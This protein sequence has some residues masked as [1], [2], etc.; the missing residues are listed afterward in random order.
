[1]LP[2]LRNGEEVEEQVWADVWSH[3]QESTVSDTDARY[4]SENKVG[5]SS[6]SPELEH[7]L[8]DWARTVYR[9]VLA[10]KVRR[11]NAIVGAYLLFGE[12]RLE[13]HA[14][15]YSKLDDIGVVLADI[16]LAPS[17]L[18]EEAMRR[19]SLRRLSW[20]MHQLNG[21]VGRAN[22]AL[23]DVQEFLGQY[24]QIGES[25]VPNE[26]KAK[27][28][29]AMPGGV[30]LDRQTL[31]N[32]LQDAMKAV[33]DVRKIAYQVR[34]L[35]RVQGA[36]PKGAF[37]LGHLLRSQCASCPERLPE[38]D[39]QT[40]GIDD[41]QVSANL[42]SI[43]EAIEEI[44]NNSFREL[45][46]RKVDS[47][48]IQVKWWA[49]HDEAWF[50][51]GD[52]ALPTD[53]RLIDDPFAEDASTYARSGRGSGLGLAIVRETF[54]A[55]GGG[56]TLTENSNENGRLPGVTFTAHFPVLRT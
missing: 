9:P 15:A 8:F 35:K 24:P 45:R 22:K 32:R 14:V 34:R 13:D 42:D 20:V 4:V 54:R 37:N 7:A 55:H 25:L 51:I 36:L 46:E 16:L 52:N 18:I 49:I 19:E 17:E 23:E 1:V 12:D 50:S 21:P 53:Q 44:L 31:A 48:L 28:R 47:P 29:S 11:G 2:S 30:G 56:C 5:Q 27:R 41:L 26:E 38:L 40:E 39:I 6:V 10:L 3:I 43:S 33:T